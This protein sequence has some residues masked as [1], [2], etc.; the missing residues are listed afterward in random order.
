M[1]IKITGPFSWL[2]S[3]MAN[4][5]DPMFGLVNLLCGTTKVDIIGDKF[6]ATVWASGRNVFLASFDLTS[7][8]ALHSAA[9]VEF[10]GYPWFIRLDDADLATPVSPLL[11]GH[12]DEEGNL[13]NWQDWSYLSYVLDQKAE[14][15]NYFGSLGNRL[16]LS[17]AV[18][19]TNSGVSVESVAQFAAE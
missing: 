18:A 6:E 9:G 3:V 14:N 15:R 8:M 7:A 2:Q 13:V 1:D 5:S 17:T 4:P 10:Q 11:P 16:P 19:L 12:E